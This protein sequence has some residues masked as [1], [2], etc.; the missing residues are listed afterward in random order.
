MKPE[1]TER[2]KYIIA[3]IKSQESGA[4]ISS[5]YPD[6]LCVLVAVVLAVISIWMT[7]PTS[8][9]VALIILIWHILKNAYATI[10]YTSDYKN[11][12]DKYDDT[13]KLLNE[14]D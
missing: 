13:I 9:Y 11:I 4:G 8:I 1:F 12:F 2:E 3:H 14:K 5:I 7:D 10:N 6:I